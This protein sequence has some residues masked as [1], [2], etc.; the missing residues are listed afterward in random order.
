LHMLGTWG[1]LG[2]QELDACNPGECAIRLK[3]EG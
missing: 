1:I 3:Y 2:M